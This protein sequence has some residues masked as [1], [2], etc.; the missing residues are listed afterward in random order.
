MDD[1]AELVALEKAN[2]TNQS[3]VGASA[4]PSTQRSRLLESSSSGTFS[5][6]T[7]E[8]SIGSS[9][10]NFRTS[11]NP[12]TSMSLDLSDRDRYGDDVPFGRTYSSRL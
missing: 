9:F 4:V 11:H 2:M 1:F 12:G 6:D 8:P 3:G 10:L 7:S 5:P